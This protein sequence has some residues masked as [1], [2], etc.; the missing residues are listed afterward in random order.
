[1]NRANL[2]WFISVLID[3]LPI[4]A[5]MDILWEWPVKFSVLLPSHS[6]IFTAEIVSL[7]ILVNKKWLCWDNKHWHGQFLKQTVVLQVWNVSIRFTCVTPCES[8]DLIRLIFDDFLRLKRS[9][10]N[11]SLIIA[12]GDLHVFP[13][14]N[15]V[16]WWS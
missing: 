14:Q 8:N 5:F 6:H 1:M 10:F 2:L 13:F 12:N 3:L 9:A 16:N 4:V 11:H 7:K 15:N